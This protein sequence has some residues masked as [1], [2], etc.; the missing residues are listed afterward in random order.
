M[1]HLIIYMQWRTRDNFYH[2]SCLPIIFSNTGTRKHSILINLT[3]MQYLGLAVAL[4]CA[5]SAAR[6]LPRD[7][8]KIPST[9]F[10][11][12]D[13]F[14]TYWSYNYP[15]GTDHNGAARMDSSHVTVGGGQLTLTAD[16]V[17]GQPPTSSGVAINYLSGTAYAQEYFTVAVSGGYDFTGQFKAPTAVGT[18][19]AF[20]L[21]G[22]NSWPPEIDLAEWKGDGKISFNT[23]GMSGAAWITDDVEYPDPSSFHQILVQ[24]RDSNGVDVSIEFHLD[25][26][27]QTTQVGAGMV[28]QP[29]W[30]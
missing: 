22:A 13:D 8:Y 2:I 20:W 29:F 12:Q 4:F 14:D 5:A 6:V 18:W 11:S 24:V 17:T 10:D 9:S 3:I 30:L 1:S 27:L 15:W 26:T 25:G 16:P 23:L 7:G 21:T 28:G 19:P